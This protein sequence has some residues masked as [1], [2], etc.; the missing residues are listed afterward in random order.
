MRGNWLFCGP[1]STVRSETET[2]LISKG[3]KAETFAEMTGSLPE[4]ELDPGYC[5]DAFQV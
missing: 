4:K 1:D 5:L 3:L 2:L